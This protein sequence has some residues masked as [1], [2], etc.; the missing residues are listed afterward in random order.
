MTKTVVTSV[1]GTH[2][3]VQ[4]HVALAVTLKKRGFRPIIC[5]TDDFEGFVTSYGV[6][7]RGLGTDMRELMKRTQ[8]DDAAALSKLLYAPNLLRE[9]QKMLKE[10]ARRTWEAAQGADA[11]IFAQT[12]T[13]CI[14]MAEALR[15]PALMVAFQPLNP[16]AEFPY[17]QYEVNPL[18]PLM[19]RFNREPFGEVPK[20]DPVVNKLSYLVQRGHQ[21]FYDLPRD[22]LRR[23][24]FG[25]KTR[26]RGG[27]A[28]NGRGEMLPILHAYSPTV[29]PAP[30]DWAPNNVITGFWRL[31]DGAGWAPD[32]DFEAFL[33][34]GDTPVYLG[35]GSMPWGA[36]RN[37]EIITKAITQWGGRAVIG[38]GW[39]GVKAEDLPKSVYV[40]D[41]APHT[42]LFKHVKA[43]VHHGGAGTTQTGLEAGR[44]TFAVPQFFDQP[45]WGKLIYEL[46]CGPQPVRLKKLTPQILATALDDL[47]NTPAYARAAEAVAEKMRLE[48]GTNRA[49]DV[50]EETIADYGSAGPRDSDT[51]ELGA[52]P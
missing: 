40:V 35:F 27:F 18:S 16:T 23:G 36:Q 46:G 48:D 50:I 32:A 29:S 26:N 4:P 15:I 25:L 5:S 8:M 44:P 3:D 30:G 45:Y 22:R 47:S 13:F 9:G 19:Y 20:I 41:R 10:A 2:G 21:M 12:T 24:M 17:F 33:S 52:A 1:L 6:E 11:L 14:D 28:R 7:F 34:T 31:D 42:E 38:K 49:V 37:T 51:Y 43:V 39:G